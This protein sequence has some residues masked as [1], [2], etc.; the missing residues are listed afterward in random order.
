MVESPHVHPGVALGDVLENDGVEHASQIVHYVA[1]IVDVQNIGQPTVREVIVKGALNIDLKTGASIFGKRKRLY[2]HLHIPPRQ[3]RGKLA[4][5]KLRIG[6]R[7]IQVY[8]VTHIKAVHHPFEVLHM[9]HL[10]QEHVIRAG[11]QPGDD[12]IVQRLRLTRICPVHLL[13]VD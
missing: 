6:A 8:I 12:V 11:C 13:E 2:E 7:D 5:E 4:R 3:K 1:G 10:V 9:L